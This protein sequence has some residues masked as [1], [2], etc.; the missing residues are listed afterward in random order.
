MGVPTVDRL[1]EEVAASE[2]QD[3]LGVQGVA[4]QT[5]SRREGLTK[6]QLQAPE[7]ASASG[8]QSRDPQGG[9]QHPRTL[10][11]PEKGSR[12]QCPE[13]IRCKALQSSHGTHLV[14]VFNPGW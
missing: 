6:K 13:N 3:V 1:T 14:D 8:S 4:L 2:E 10:Q 12:C 11:C 7:P 9:C 5:M